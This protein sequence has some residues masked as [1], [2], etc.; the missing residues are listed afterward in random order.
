MVPN[1]AKHHIKK[2]YFDGMSEALVHVYFFWPKCKVR[3]PS[4]TIR[5]ITFG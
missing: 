3:N 1:R 2:H 4:E 5:K